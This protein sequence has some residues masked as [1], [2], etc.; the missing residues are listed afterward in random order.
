V[1]LA[2]DQI[3]PGRQANWDARAAANF[4]GGGSGS[5]LLLAAAVADAVG[6][7]YRPFA[8]VALALIAA[9]L[10]CVWLEIG[11]PWRALNVFLH[12]RTSW[13]TRESL[14][15]AALFAAGAAALWQDG[16]AYAG[17]AAALA[18]AFLWCQAQILRAAKGIPA[19]RAPRVV[20]LVLVTALVEGAGFLAI[21]CVLPAPAHALSRATAGALAVLLVLR[22][23]AWRG[24]RARLSAPRRALAA[25]DRAAPLFHRAGNWVAACLAAIAALIAP[26]ALAAP[27]GALAGAIAVAAGWQLKFILVA[28]AGFNQ[29]FALPRLPVRASGAPGRA[30]KP[31]W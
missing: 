6:A 27:L 28:R 16:G 3:E 21:A 4:I 9:G 13:M 12:P 23:V 31:G 19:W 18:A 24:Y 29:G 1:S 30:A 5:G 25:L 17:V 11:R 14:A 15:A 2:A 20:P 7:P 10:A 22:A 8:A 26:D